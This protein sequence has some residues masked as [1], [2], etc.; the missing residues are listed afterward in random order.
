MT[1]MIKTKHMLLV[2]MACASLILPGCKKQDDASNQP[3][4]PGA[5]GSGSSMN[6]VKPPAPRAAA[7]KADPASMAWI[8]AVAAKAPA[9]S[10]MLFALRRVDE[11]TSL[12]RDIGGDQALEMMR[13][14]PPPDAQALMSI[15]LAEDFGAVGLDPA[16]PLS[17]AVNIDVERKLATN[18]VRVAA[19]DSSKALAS[20]RS[21]LPPTVPVDDVNIGGR[22]GFFV[23]GTIPVMV[24]ADESQLVIVLVSRR[25]S[26]EPLAV[27]DATALATERLDVSRVLSD[28]PLFADAMRLNQGG[29]VAAFFNLEQSS[30]KLAAMEEPMPSSTK[31]IRAIGASLNVADDGFTLSLRKSLVDES[32]WLKKIAAPKVDMLAS[33]PNYM[34]LGLR[35]RVDPAL[36]LSSMR[37]ASA[38]SSQAKMQM[39]AM[40]DAAQ[41]ALGISLNELAAHLSGDLGLFVPSLSFASQPPIDLVSVMG[42]KNEADARGVLN[43]A[44]AQFE[45]GDAEGQSPLTRK[46]V[47][48]S[49]M[50][51]VRQP[52]QPAVA[53]GVANG[54]M[55]IGWPEGH[56]STAMSGGPEAAAAPSAAMTDALSGNHL[57]GLYFNAT[58][59]I[60]MAPMFTQGR[61][62][63]LTG[64]QAS[65]EPITVVADIDG[66]AVDSVLRI[67]VEMAAVRQAVRSMIRPAA[68]VLGAPPVDEVQ[69]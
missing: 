2:A 33:V 57:A 34:M 12:I 58:P 47:G 4:A 37:D 32:P 54:A 63:D 42:V 46:A 3:A 23:S 39:R 56:I 49:E 35:L 5:D 36:M 27:D 21:A 14:S 24:L 50:L 13:K 64:I 30:S 59:L 43:S 26:V 55:W 18:T 62:P 10:D 22:D 8:T 1:S 11:I 67:P 65:L 19:K 25:G 41:R 40:E 6:S 29:R 15:V 28:Q 44:V 60:A 17:F 61:G 51:V 53:S 7:S 52:N 38:A 9:D 66:N 68:P 48:G 31:D 20:F 69:P 45:V 16:G